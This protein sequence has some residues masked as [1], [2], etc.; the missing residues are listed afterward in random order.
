MLV[1]LQEA[2]RIGSTS[3]DKLGRMVPD[4]KVVSR[5]LYI[6]PDHIIS[7]N[8]DIEGTRITNKSLSRLETVKGAFTVFGTPSEIENKILNFVE[9]KQKMVLRD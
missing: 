7:I 4:S 2:Q 6:N 8:E 5:D 3:I 9:N 1:K